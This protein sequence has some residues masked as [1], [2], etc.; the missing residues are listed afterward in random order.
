[1]KALITGA[2]GAVGRA[3]V[4]RLAKDGFEVW[5][6]YRS[7]QDQAVSLLEEVESSGGRGRL[8]P[9]DIRNTDEIDENLL[10]LLSREGPLDVLVNNAGI[11]SEGYLMMLPEAQWK[12]VVDVNLTGVFLVTRACLKGMVQQRS[13]RVVNIGSLA[14]AK[15]AVGQGAYAAS[16]AGLEGVTRVLAQEM[17]RWN[18]LVNTVA[19]GP[20]EEGMAQKAEHEKF[21]SQIPLG[22][23]GRVEEV[24]GVVSFLS[25][26][27]ASYITGQVIAVN[28]GMGM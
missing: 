20:L 3:V 5:I 6:H 19:P 27:D 24:A 18:I 25:S 16:K 1:L 28:G 9:F 12:E 10:P 23:L 2:G 21:V 7:S 14:G 26:D 11:A 22:R 4:R 13:G 17:A 15:G 8:V